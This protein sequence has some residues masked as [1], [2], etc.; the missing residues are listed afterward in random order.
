MELLPGMRKFTQDWCVRNLAQ[1]PADTDISFESWIQKA[2]YPRWRKRELT[3]SW[4]ACD[5]QLRAEHKRVSSFIK[6][7]GYDTWK[8]ARWINSRSDEFKCFAG[9]WI[10]ALSKSI[11]QRGEFIKTVPVS[12]RPQFIIDRI[13][14]EGCTYCCTD[15]TAYEAHFTADIMRNIEFVV[16]H[17]VLANVPGAMLFLRIFSKAVC[18]INKCRNKQLRMSV[19]AKRMSGEF[20]TSIGNGIANEL[21]LEFL[22]ERNGFEFTAVY[23]GDDSLFV[24]TRGEPPTREMYKEIGFDVKIETFQALEEASFC[25]LVFD[26]ND[27]AVIADA[28]RHLAEVGVS[29]AKYLCVRPYKKKQ[30]LR[31]KGFSFVYQYPGCPILQALGECILRCTADVDMTDFV[32][33]RLHYQGEW[34]Q[35]QIQSALGHKHVHVPVGHGSRLLMEKKFNIGVDVQLKL[36][37]YFLSKTKYS[38]IDV[39]IDLPVPVDFFPKEW[40]E[41]GET[42]VFY[43]HRCQTPSDSFLSGFPSRPFDVDVWH[44]RH[45]P[46]AYNGNGRIDLP[47]GQL[48][49]LAYANN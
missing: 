8:H 49:A 27:R 11:F 2:P 24:I 42:Y 40:H 30:L 15:Y 1:L 33:S 10:S 9:P 43:E 26:I 23:E 47:P 14:R 16:Y 25:G 28:K 48:R 38:E 13:F 17:H 39:L 18:G 4:N 19:Q 21:L 7:E 5:R 45:Q 41:F 22:G 35:A 37:E 3:R 44:R 20:T 36:E 12:Q 32:E 6:D 31:S 29:A 34:K 46:Y